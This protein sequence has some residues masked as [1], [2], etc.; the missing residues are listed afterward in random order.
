MREFLFLLFPILVSIIPL[1]IIAIQKMKRNR[2]LSIDVIITIAA[3]F[4]LTIFDGLEIYFKEYTTNIAM[5]TLFT[6]TGYSLRPFYLILFMMLAK[7]ATNKIW[8]FFIPL[9]INAVFYYGAFA[10]DTAFGQLTF[11]YSVNEA[12]TALTFNR[13][14]INFLV[15][16]ISGAY[17]LV[18]FMRSVNELNGR[19]RNE[20]SVLL[21]CGIAVVVALIIDIIYRS[22]IINLIVALCLIFYYLFLVFQANKL[23]ELTKA[24]DRR[25]FY[26][27]I[28]NNEKRI[29]AIIQLDMNGLKG[30]NDGQGHHEGD[31]ALVT[32]SQ[33]MLDRITRKMCLYRMGGDEFII[34]CYQEKEE[35]IIKVIKDIR[36]DVEETI[37]SI[38]IGY[39]MRKDPSTDLLTVSYEAEKNMYR[40][41][42]IY[43]ENSDAERRVV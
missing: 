13:G 37:Y 41:K 1:F 24:F 32:V 4:L 7:V 22:P 5:A 43:Y 39:C 11:W 27:D 20:A 2:R 42:D 34:L 21:G 6:A 8:I 35:N 15:H 18:V 30:I 40:D 25:T 28:I 17:V 29:N 14:I 26:E 16:I 12:G 23:D 31:I 9:A 19:H 36:R 10:S 33:I 3:I 38:A